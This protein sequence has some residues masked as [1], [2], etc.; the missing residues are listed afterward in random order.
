M[1]KA[2]LEFDYASGRELFERTF[3]ELRKE[4]PNGIKRG[5]RN[6]TPINLYEA[7]AVGAAD[8]IAR[9]ETII[10]KNV[11]NWINDDDLKKLTSGAT[12]SRKRLKDRIEYCS[13]RFSQ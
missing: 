3:D 13:E 7:I 12:N 10:G 4:L 8:S 6:V 1:Q 9:G 2:S 11:A 5:N